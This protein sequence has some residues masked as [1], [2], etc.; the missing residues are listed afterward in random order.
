MKKKQVG[1]A[2]K[3]NENVTL[4]KG[5]LNERMQS[6]TE[7]LKLK[8]SLYEPVDLVFNIIP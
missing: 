3:Q 8:T 1:I 7:K 5:N 2:M 4:E 6:I